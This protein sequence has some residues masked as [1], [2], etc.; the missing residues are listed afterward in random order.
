MSGAVRQPQQD[1][2]WRKRSNGAEVTLYGRNLR[3]DGWAFCYAGQVEES[4]EGDAPGSEFVH[5]GADCCWYGDHVFRDGEFDFVRSG[6]PTPQAGDTWTYQYGSMNPITRTLS[7]HTVDEHGRGV[8]RWADSSI[9]GGWFDTAWSNPDIKMTLVSREGAPVERDWSRWLPPAPLPDTG[10]KDFKVGQSW[11][12]AAR[13]GDSVYRMVYRVVAVS[14]T[15]IAYDIL[16]L[17]VNGEV[18]TPSHTRNE[19]NR[20]DGSV[21]RPHSALAQDVGEPEPR[22]PAVVFGTAPAT[23]RRVEVGDVYRG[24]LTAHT[25]RVTGLRPRVADAMRDDG[26]RAVLPVEEDG[27]LYSQ[28]CYT[29]V[30]T[31]A[32]DSAV[33]ACVPKR[34]SKTE[35]MPPPPAALPH[36]NDCQCRL[37]RP[38]LAICASPPKEIQHYGNQKATVLKAPICGRITRSGLPC[39]L[40]AGHPEKGCRVLPKPRLYRFCSVNV[41]LNGAPLKTYKTHRTDPYVVSRTRELLCVECGADA[42]GMR[43]SDCFPVPN[44]RV[45]MERSFALE[46]DR[47]AEMEASAR[48]AAPGRYDVRDLLAP[49]GLGAE[50]LVCPVRGLRGAVSR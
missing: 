27:S 25:Y 23:P 20:D 35:T 12:A 7:L 9:D 28:D 44:W 17:T 46:A 8:W 38:D 36:A 14:A 48:V 47:L 6:T 16:A 34:G 10:P 1:D 45:E 29:L 39:D 40:P 32:A 15:H 49:V 19:W 18:S 2:V 11:A 22:D 26:A 37:C 3:N 42:K 4:R 30:S 21:Y 33:R 43:A 41:T 50:T 31:G 5:R 13:S 24:K